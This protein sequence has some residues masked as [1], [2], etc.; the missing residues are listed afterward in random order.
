MNGSSKSS[1]KLAGIKDDYRGV[2][3]DLCSIYKRKIRQLETTYNFERF[4]SAPL[5]D[6]DIVAKPMVL[7]LGQYSTV[8]SFAQLVSLRV[9][10]SIDIKIIIADDIHPPKTLLVGKDDIYQA[11]DRF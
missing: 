2:Y 7:L 8:R 9:R 1:Q 3:A 4:H 6:S 10:L 5:T 11:S